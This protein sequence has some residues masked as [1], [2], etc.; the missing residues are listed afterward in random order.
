MPA[1]L[2]PQHK[3]LIF[4]R[5]HDELLNKDPGITVTMDDGEEIRLRPTNE[6]SK[7]A[8]KGYQ[9][10]FLKQLEDSKSTWN[11]LLPFLQ[12]IVMAR[13]MPSA[14]FWEK[15]TRKAG[16]AGREGVLLD[17]AKSVDKTEF[18]LSRPG[19]A[20]EFFI[21]FHRRAAADGFKGAT[22][23]AVWNRAQNVALMLE[24]PDHIQRK[25]NNASEAGERQPEESDQADVRSDP[26]VLATLL[27][28]S[29]H[30]ALKDKTDS[31]KKTV[32]SYATKVAYII[33]NGLPSASSTKDGKPTE[34]QA[35][36]MLSNEVEAGVIMEEAIKTALEVGSV[37]ADDK[38]TLKNHLDTLSK[39]LQ[40]QVKTLRTE[41]ESHDPVRPR[42]S[43]L[44]YTQLHS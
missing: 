17:C 18:R 14:H 13:D 38:V 41:A 31:L 1:A 26:T 8:R 10:Q 28:L 30:M 33:Q 20:R 22:L 42:R 34:A 27:E 6:M 15:L 37:K 11:N 12:G 23:E 16:E 4:R 19:V 36:I 35:R 21:A 32:A 29:S 24:S 39:K 25:P 44:M 43:L 2:S 7:P 40:R 5:R 9:T 3:R